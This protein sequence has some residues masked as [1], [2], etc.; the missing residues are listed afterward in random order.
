VVSAFASNTLAI[1]PILG[2][3]KTRENQPIVINGNPAAS[4]ITVQG[5]RIHCP[6]QT[7]ATVDLGSV[8]RLEIDGNT[9]LALSFS[10]NEVQVELTAGRVVLT[11]NKGVTGT[12]NTSEGAVFA[13][14]ASRQSTVTAWTSASADL[15]TQSSQSASSKSELTVS[16]EPLAGSSRGCAKF[17]KRGL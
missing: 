15:K 16:S 1:G 5:A 4:G 6:E 12:I 3:L 2:K 17:G 7:S 8:A 11:T 9:D 13:T 10:P 14:D